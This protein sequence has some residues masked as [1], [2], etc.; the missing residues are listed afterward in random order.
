MDDRKLGNFFRIVVSGVRGAISC[1]VGALLVTFFNGKKG[2]QYRENQKGDPNIN[3][4]EQEQI[5]K[6]NKKCFMS[7]PSTLNVL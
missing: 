1:G 4:P 6:Q 2:S 5:T 7:S 3:Q